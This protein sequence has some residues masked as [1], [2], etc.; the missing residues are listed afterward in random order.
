MWES[1]AGVFLCNES[2]LCVSERSLNGKIRLSWKEETIMN[3]SENKIFSVPLSSFPAALGFRKP[4]GFQ[5][6]PAHLEKLLSEDTPTEDGKAGSVCLPLKPNLMFCD[7]ERAQM[8]DNT[9]T[10]T[11][12]GQAVDGRLG[13]QP[14]VL[15]HTSGFE[16]LLFVDDD[17]LGV[18]HAGDHKPV[19]PVKVWTRGWCLSRLLIGTVEKHFLCVISVMNFSAFRSSATATSAPSERPPVFIKVRCLRKS[20]DFWVC[21]EL[22]Q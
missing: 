20:F 8:S 5:D 1:C 7:S 16:G 3:N 10:W 12:A 2:G 14:V 22:T 17:L 19:K 18:R 13:P 6:L 11:C 21:A 4:L 9:V 15:D